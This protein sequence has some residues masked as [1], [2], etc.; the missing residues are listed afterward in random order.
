MLP[1]RWL[2]SPT[3][4]STTEPRWSVRRRR[5][6]STQRWLPHRRQKERRLAR[7]TEAVVEDGTSQDEVDSVDL[8]HRPRR[9][10]SNA[11]A[12]VSLGTWPGTV[13]RN[14][15]TIMRIHHRLQGRVG[16]G[17]T[18]AE[19]GDT[20]PEIVRHS[21]VVDLVV[22]GEV[23]AAGIEAAPEMMDRTEGSV[24]TWCRRTR[25]PR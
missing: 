7:T 23:G 21:R 14:K 5:R 19:D 1:V 20:W 12:V 16:S 8:S 17:V 10:K 15:S 4:T 22:P 18:T 2:R 11:M 25:Q 24:S 3:Y 9:R 13:P 6:A